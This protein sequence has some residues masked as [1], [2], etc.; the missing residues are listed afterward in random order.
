MTSLFVTV[1]NACLLKSIIV[2][3]FGFSLFFILRAELSF[4]RLARYY[5][6]TYSLLQIITYY[7]GIG[8]I[9]HNIFLQYDV[10]V[11]FGTALYSVC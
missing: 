9:V 1:Y 3:L 2:D 8:F 4:N 6:L 7:I 5:K 11:R 10:V